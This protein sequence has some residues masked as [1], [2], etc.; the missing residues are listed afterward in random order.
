MENGVVEAIAAGRFIFGLAFLISAVL[1]FGLVGMHTE[2]AKRYNIPF[3]RVCVIATV[4][5]LVLLSAMI[6]FEIWVTPAAIGIGAAL[7]IITPLYHDFWKFTGPERSRKL[8]HL[9]ENVAVFGALIVLA[10]VYWN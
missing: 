2:L 4:V 9:L 1:N 7:A 8:H 6:T 5:F 10:A 3:P